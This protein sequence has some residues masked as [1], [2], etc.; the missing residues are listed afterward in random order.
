MDV[1][2]QVK[3][4]STIWITISIVA[5]F[6]GAWWSYSLYDMRKEGSTAV[7]TV[8][9]YEKTD[10]GETVCFFYTI[11]FTANNREDYIIRLDLSPDYAKVGDEIDLMYNP[12]KP[13]GA[14][15]LDD[16]RHLYNCVGGLLFLLA[17]IGFGFWCRA[18][19]EKVAPYVGDV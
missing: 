8:V 15:V 3:I 19:P 2:K 9:N 5:W 17:F 14:Q 18:N 4:V 11:Q 12:Q 16:K 10:C 6:L 7:G 1:I 13:E